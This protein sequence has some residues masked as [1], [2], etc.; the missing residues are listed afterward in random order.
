MTILLIP[1]RLHG[2]SKKNTCASVEMTGAYCCYDLASYLLIK[3]A[4]SYYLSDDTLRR[5]ASLVCVD[6]LMPVMAAAL[7]KLL[8]ESSYMK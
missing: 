1:F 4:I 6:L 7:V 2:N 3:L 8:E 5:F